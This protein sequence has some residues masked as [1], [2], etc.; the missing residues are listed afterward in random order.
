MYK[1]DLEITFNPAIFP[2]FRIKVKSFDISFYVKSVTHNMAYDSSGFTTRVEC[3][4]P[5]GT[6]VSGMVDP[7]KDVGQTDS[8]TSTTS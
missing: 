6:L 8:T 5:V 1:A 4:C 7:K 2:G 3:T